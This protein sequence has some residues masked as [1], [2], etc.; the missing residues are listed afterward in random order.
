MKYKLS[1]KL[2]KKITYIQ[3]NNSYEKLFIFLFWRPCLSLSNLI[4]NCFNF[5]FKVWFQNRRAKFRK[6]ERAKQQ[7]QSQSSSSVKQEP[8]N[9]SGGNNSNNNNSSSSNNNNNNTCKD[10][11]IKS[12]E[13]QGQLN[14]K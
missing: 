3:F 6:M 11:I 13:G 2:A 4:L 5:Y 14:R 12:E 1:K 8:S 10:K 9:N 7:Q